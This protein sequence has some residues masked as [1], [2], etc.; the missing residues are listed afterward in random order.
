MLQK[1]ILATYHF[2]R[3]QYPFNEIRRSFEKPSRGA[4]S[5]LR[6]WI[7]PYRTSHYVALVDAEHRADLVV[8]ENLDQKN[9]DAMKKALDAYKAE[10]AEANGG[11][12]PAAEVKM[13]VDEESSKKDKKKKRKSLAAEETVRRFPSLSLL[14]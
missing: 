3:S 2:R 7:Q 9:A 13:D 4:T 6:I 11:E 8:F 10:V 12:E 14:P 1:L 5:V